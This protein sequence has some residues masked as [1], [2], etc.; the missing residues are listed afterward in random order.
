M[1]EDPMT[2]KIR[3]VKNVALMTAMLQR[4]VQVSEFNCK[5]LFIKNLSSKLPY[6]ES[7]SENLKTTVAEAYHLTSKYRRIENPR[8]T[9]KNSSAK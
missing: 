4:H 2:N 6:P 1:T 8:N 9:P 5:D 3:N 7:L